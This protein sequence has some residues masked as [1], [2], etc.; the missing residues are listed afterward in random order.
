[1]R[2]LGT[3]SQVRRAHPSRS[4]MLSEVHIVRE[5]DAVIAA[6][7]IVAVAIPLALIVCTFRFASRYPLTHRLYE[8]LSVQLAYERKET[9]T[10]LPEEELGSLE[11]T[12]I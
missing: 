4:R 3:H 8:R 2:G 7:R 9:D 11:R 1:M 12:L 5:L 10:G 6:L